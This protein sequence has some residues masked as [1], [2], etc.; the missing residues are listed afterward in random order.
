MLELLDPGK[1]TFLMVEHLL[2]IVTVTALQALHCH[3]KTVHCVA[4]Q[5]GAKG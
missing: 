5:S 3:C 4:R 2:S 1:A